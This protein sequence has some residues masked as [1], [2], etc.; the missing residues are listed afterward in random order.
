[1]SSAVGEI[2]Q[3]IDIVDLISSYI[4]VKKKGAYFAACCPFHVEKTASFMINPNKQSFS[5]YGCGK[6]GDHFTFV[7]EYENMTFPET[8]RLLA[9]QAGV[10]LEEYKSKKKT[11]DNSE[12]ILKALECAQKYFRDSFLSEKGKQARDYIFSRG[13][14]EDC[15]E[16]FGIGYSP[17]SWQGLIDYSKKHNISE[18]TLELASLIKIN[19]N[20]RA[21]DFFRNRVMFPVKNEQ[22]II[23]GFGGRVLDN[24]EPKY[25]NSSETEVFR[26]SRL[27]FNMDNA[28]KTIREHKCLIVVEGYTDVMMANQ[29]SL[30]PTVATLGTALTEDHVASLK[31]YDIPIYLVYD[32][33]KAGQNATERVL[34]YFLKYGV[35]NKT[36]TLPEKMDPCDFLL[37]TENWKE[38]WNSLVKNSR[39]LFT[40]KLNRK[41]NEITD[42][43]LEAK[44]RIGNEMFGDLKVCKDNLRREIYLDYLAKKLDIK[45]KSFNHKQAEP[46]EK[47]IDKPKVKRYTVDKD[48]SYLLLAVMLIDS[49]YISILEEEPNLNIPQN[50]SGSILK[51]WMN[52]HQ[53]PSPIAYSE[54]AKNL[55]EKE[56]FIFSQA[57]IETLLPGKNKLKGF[58]IEQI[59]KLSS[60]KDTKLS[61]LDQI[62][63]AE[64]EGNLERVAELMSKFSN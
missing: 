41:L 64:K 58:F 50:T 28:K 15:V 19:D 59:K 54:F 8:L 16:K 3:R 25:L 56:K 26:K 52:N 46:D 43:D 24:S 38:S 5:C 53:D 48:P 34:P 60:T 10:E 7:Q 14:T 47:N 35:Q 61:I 17:E 63:T 1:M 18:K 62:A 44:V 36:I 9:K 4:T 11:V 29:H 33:D 22:G 12:E 27:L 55:N 23:T 37:K 49:N 21:F 30:G 51:K 20:K 42:D 31:K 6:F 45:R 39:D 57:G 2:K 13:F 32:G 40:F